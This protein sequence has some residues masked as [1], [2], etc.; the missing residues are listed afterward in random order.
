MGRV[1]GG[2][3]R[4]RE[5]AGGSSGGTGSS[6]GGSGSERAEERGGWGE[7]GLGPG[8]PLRGERPPR[9]LDALRAQL[10]LRH[11]SPSTEK[12]YVGWVRHFIHFHGKRHPAEMGR[13]EVEAFLTHLAMSRNVSAGTQ[14]QALNGLLFF[15][16]YVIGRDLGALS[17]VVR[18]RRPSR[19]PVVLSVEETERV[20]AELSGDMRTVALLLWG[21]GLR[22]LEALRLRVQDVDFERR[23][24]RIRDGKGRRDRL[25]VLP[26]RAV[27][28]LIEKVAEVRAL[29]AQDL[30]D[31]FGEVELP[32]A[33]AR[34]YPRAGYELGWQW[35]F[36]ADRM[37]ACPRTGRVGRHH[38]FETTVQ[39]HGRDAGVRAGIE[40]R[41]T[42]HVFRHSFATALIESGYDIRTVQELLGHQNVSTT[43]IYTHVLNRGGRGVLSPADRGLGRGDG[44]GGLPGSASVGGAIGTHGRRLPAERSGRSVSNPRG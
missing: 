41:V 3:L 2:G 36:P 29:H 37:S 27:D 32:G 42:P 7:F 35:V 6:W 5:G 1:S 30:A 18:A 24:L 14:N 10:R 20:I 25:T 44:R 4:G 28:A 13:V 22:L 43:M 34:K 8:S 23:E 26:E 11:R 16:R 38:L 19:I 31:G 15:Y 40:K 12:S 21:G 33:L 39:R 17:E 9:V